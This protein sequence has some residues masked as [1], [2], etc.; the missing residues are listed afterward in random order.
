MSFSGSNTAEKLDSDNHGPVRAVVVDDSSVIRGFLMRWLKEDDEIDVVGSASNGAMAIKTVERLRPEVVLLDIEMP[1]MDGITALPEL[2][3]VAPGVKVIMVS[4]LTRRNAEISLKATSLGAADYITKPESAR[5][6]GANEE[7]RRELIGK[8]KVY[9]LAGRG[10]GATTSLRSAPATGA[11]RAVPRLADIAGPSPTQIKLLPATGLRPDVL[12][13][14]SSTGGPQALFKFL[15]ALKGQ[16][17]VPVVITQHMPATFTAILAEHIAK[18]TGMP[19]M[20]GKDNQLAKAGE[21][22]VAPGGYHMTVSSSTQGPILHLDQNPPENFCRPSVDPMFRSLAKHYGKRALGVVL[23][24][25]GHDGL[26]GGQEIVNAGGMIVAQDEASSVVW[27]MPGAVANAGL[28]C[29]VVD[30]DAMGGEVGRLM[31]GA[32]S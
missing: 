17:R 32:M 31:A 13:I 7:F 8:V 26:A 6:I 16:L 4:T 1:E 5:A 14:G 18:A 15:S 23:T 19:C 28:C 10:D 12:G 30:I 22:Y 25:M 9:G 11:A 3:R 21:I 20:E 29:R 2:L 24:G 27:G